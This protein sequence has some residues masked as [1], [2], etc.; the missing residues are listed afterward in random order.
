MSLQMRFFTIPIK[1]TEPATEEMNRFLRSVRVIAVKK[2]FFP[3]ADGACWLVA[4]EYQT[5]DGESRP[6]RGQMSGKKK[7]DYK[8]ILSPDDFSIYLRLRDWR[9]AT[10]DKEATQLFNIF[11]ND[12]LATIV[13]DKI[14]TRAGLKAIGG[15]GDARVEKYGDAV[16]AIMKEEIARLSNPAGQENRHE[17]GESP[18]SS[19]SDPGKSPKGVPEGRKGK[20][21]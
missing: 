10:G 4:V 13:Q 5:G 8:E 9:K 2:E 3:D 21:P 7:V 14:T 16:I 20:A 19:H 17:T 6:A 1:D 12:Q 11:T 15:V 18:V